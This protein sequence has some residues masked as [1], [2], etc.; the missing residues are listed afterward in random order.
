MDAGARLVISIH[1]RHDMQVMIRWRDD[2]A[3]Q[4]Q[5]ER[6]QIVSEK[7][8]FLFVAVPGTYRTRQYEIS[9]TD[10]APFVLISMEEEVEFLDH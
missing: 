8:D 10:E 1:Q 2:R 5:E 7:L 6:Q 4:W 9:F 3:R